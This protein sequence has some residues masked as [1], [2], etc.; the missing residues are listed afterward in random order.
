MCT[1]NYFS[2]YLAPSEPI[3]QSHNVLNCE[4]LVIQRI[5]LLMFKYSHENVPV[6]VSQLFRTKN[7]YHNYNTRNYAHINAPAA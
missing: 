6:S 5:S 1:H 4:M 2:E 3:F 7:E